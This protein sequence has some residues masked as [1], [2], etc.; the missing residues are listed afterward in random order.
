MS[1]L[2]V[3]SFDTEEA[4]TQALHALR[5]LEHEGKIHFGR[6]AKVTVSYHYL[7]DLICYLSPH[8]GHH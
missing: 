8:G 5:G 3:L 4:A 1:E 2:F 6:R 7:F